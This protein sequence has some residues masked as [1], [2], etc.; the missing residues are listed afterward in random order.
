MKALEDEC[1]ENGLNLA[2]DTLYSILSR[3]GLLG[4]DTYR[5]R[6]SQ[7]RIEIDH[8]TSY[9]RDALENSSRNAM[10][11]AKSF[12]EQFANLLQSALIAAFQSINSRVASPIER[13]QNQEAWEALFLTLRGEQADTE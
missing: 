13:A 2:P 11:T 5:F 4:L 1:R 6:I 12:Y 10:G 7:N 8:F 9:C 3:E